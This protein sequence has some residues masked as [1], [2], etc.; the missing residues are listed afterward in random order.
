MVPRQTFLFVQ[1]HSTLINVTMSSIRHAAGPP[2]LAREA[3]P[4]AALGVAPH[5]VLDAR[6]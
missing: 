3:E 5:A 1:V 2:T 6:P 4:Q